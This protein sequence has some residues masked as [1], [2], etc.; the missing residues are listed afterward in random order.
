[1]SILER[2]G[3]IMPKPRSEQISI[4]DTPSTLSFHAAYDAH[5]YAAKIVLVYEVSE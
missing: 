3:I 4:A 1:M 2:Q 5:S